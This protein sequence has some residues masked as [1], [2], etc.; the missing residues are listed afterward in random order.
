MGSPTRDAPRSRA[1]RR[2]A[3]GGAR[4]SPASAGAGHPRRSPTKAELATT[5][6]DSE[7]IESVPIATQAGRRRAGRDVA[8]TRAAAAPIEV[9]DRLRV[10]G[11]VQVS[12][13]CVDARAALRRPPLRVQPDDHRADRALAEPEG[14][15]G[16][17]AAVASR[18]GALQAAAP[19][20]KP[21]LHARDPEHRD[22]D[23]RPRGA[24][25][26]RRRLLR[27]PDRRRL[28][29]EGR[30]A[31][32][33]SCSAA[34][35]PTARSRRTRAGSTWSR[36]APTSRRRPSARAATLVNAVAA[37]D[38]GDSEKRRVIHSVA[39]RRAA[40]GRG[41]RLRRRASS[42]DDQRAALQ[43]LHLLAGD[44]RRRPDR[45]PSRPGWR[46][47]RSRS[48]AQ[49]HRVERLQLHPG[50]ERLREPVHD[51]SRRA[52]SGSPRRGRQ[53]TGEPATLY[54][55][56]VAAAKPLLAEKRRQARP[57]RSRSRPDRRAHASRATPP[58]ERA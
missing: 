24:A 37:A 5:G 29:Q 10:S 32:T 19:E 54:L 7:L 18:S 2:L 51:A 50:R 45:R 49:A 4:R 14:R 36:R 17:P 27:E 44:P 33:S 40:Q 57:T 23:R 30:S 52:R 15:L 16:L 38:E 22:A 43:H 25:V 53:R 41:A 47:P 1:A 20:P 48:R 6:N 42:T 12:T 28:E 55:N 11:E 3:A 9:G 35:S 34:T 56:L 8:R 39:D 13:T 31:A 26:R 58:D 46:R 21:P